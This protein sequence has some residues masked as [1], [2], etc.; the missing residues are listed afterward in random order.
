[1]KIIFSHILQEKLINKEPFEI[2]SFDGNLKELIEFINGKIPGF[3]D[4]VL[5]NSTIK[6]SVRIMKNLTKR[7]KN[8][9]GGKTLTL[10]D[11]IIADNVKN[12]MFSFFDPKNLK[13]LITLF[14]RKI[15]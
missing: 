12:I 2:S 3:L 5:S 13:D 4:I 11:K 1:M 14:Y 8:Y 7:N 15:L 10:E 6:S 9:Y